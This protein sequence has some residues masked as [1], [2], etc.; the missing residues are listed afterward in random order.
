MGVFLCFIIILNIL[1]FKINIRR[2]DLKK[3]ECI[4]LIMFNLS[5]DIVL[6]IFKLNIDMVVLILLINVFSCIFMTDIKCYLIYDDCNLIIFL[7]GILYFVYQFNNK[8]LSECIIMWIFIVVMVIIN[9]I[10]KKELIGFGDLKLMFSMSLYLGLIGS[11]FSLFIA[12]ILGVISGMLLKKR[13]IP[14][15]PYLVCGYISM[16]IY[17]NLNELFNL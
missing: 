10:L 13:L 7:C 9:K 16:F 8:L 15:G 12:S 11:W 17:L 2:G 14:F 6:S 1:L 4:G 5:V 3:N